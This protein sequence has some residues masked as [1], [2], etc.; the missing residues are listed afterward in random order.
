MPN[1]IKMPDNTGESKNKNPNEC[2]L[3]VPITAIKAVA[4]PGGWVVRVSCIA[5]MDKATA[6]AQHSHWQ[7]TPAK[8]L[9]KQMPMSAEIV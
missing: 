8:H 3:L 4:P 2:T 9:N 5:N 1:K 7:S 6:K